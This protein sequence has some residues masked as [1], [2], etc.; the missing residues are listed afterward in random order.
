MRPGSAADIPIAPDA[1]MTAEE[2]RRRTGFAEFRLYRRLGS[3]NTR[4]AELIHAGELKLP[5]AVVAMRQTRGRG[6][7]ANTWYSDAGS[8]TMTLVLPAEAGRHDPELPLRAGLAVRA[9]AAGYVPPARLRIKWPNDVLADGRK[10][11]GILCERVR[12]AVLIGIGVNVTTEL[13]AAPPEVRAKAVSLSELCG[14][15]VPRADVLVKVAAAVES[16]F[17]EAADW[18]AELNRVHA[19]NGGRITVDVGGTMV[20]GVCR[21]VDPAGRLLLDDGKTTHAVSGGHVV[22]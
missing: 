19:L 13:D 11:A 20:R 2:L 6:R 22:D 8:L 14:R 10:L 5:A 9:A 17:R 21:G 3:T 15:F 1:G 12:D 7:G 4:A 18:H 16:A